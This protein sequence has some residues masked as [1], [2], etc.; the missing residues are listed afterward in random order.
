MVNNTR[1]FGLEFLV[2][3]QKWSSN[4]VY[5]YALYLSDHN[6][7]NTRFKIFGYHGTPT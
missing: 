5:S 2:G 7:S 3:F 1:Q 6:D 4:K